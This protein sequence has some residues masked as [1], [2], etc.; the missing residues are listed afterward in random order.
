MKKPSQPPGFG[1]R[2]GR[3]AQPAF[4]RWARDRAGSSSARIGSIG[5]AAPAAP[6]RARPPAA[7]ASRPHRPA[8]ARL[9]PLGGARQHRRLLRRQRRRSRRADAVEHVGMAAID[10]GRRA[11]RVEQD[12]V[13]GFGGLP[14][15]HVGLDERRRQ[16]RC[17]RDCR[18]SRARR[19]AARGRRGDLPAGGGELQRLAAGRGAQVERGAPSPARR[20]GARGARR[21][22]PAPTRRP[23]HSRAASVDIRRRRGGDGPASGW[24]RRAAPP[25]SAVSAGSASVRSSGGRPARPARAASTASSPQAPAQRSPRPA[26]ADAA[27]RAAS[28]RARISVPNTPWTSRRG[29]PSTRRQHGARSRHAAACRARAPAPARCA[30]RSAP[31]RRRAAA[32]CVAESI[33]ASRSGRWRSVSDAIARARPR[34][35]GRLSTPASPTAPPR[36]AGRGAAPHRAGAAPRG[37]RACRRVRSRV[38]GRSWVAHRHCARPILRAGDR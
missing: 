17:G 4:G 34:S 9:Q 23:R 12:R 14:A 21:R 38:R 32:C 28:R 18:E 33:S 22:C 2:A 8:A 19:I 20:A 36:A 16:A 3:D 26:S 5:E 6:R 37:A 7:R 10:A 24:S 1:E 30:A 35:S 31:W 11:G 25:M 27:D 13:G 29:P 15:H